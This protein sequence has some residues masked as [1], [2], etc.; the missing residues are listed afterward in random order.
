MEKQ[1]KNLFSI[2]RIVIRRLKNVLNLTKWFI[3][4]NSRSMRKFV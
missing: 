1:Q 2:I 3:T 4:L